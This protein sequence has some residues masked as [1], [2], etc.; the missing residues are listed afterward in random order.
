MREPPHFFAASERRAAATEMQSQRFESE[1]R[2][3]ARQRR[4]KALQQPA[5]QRRIGERAAMLLQDWQ[6]Q[7]PYQRDIEQDTLALARSHV[8]S[9]PTPCTAPAHARADP[10]QM[11]EARKV[12]P[13][14]DKIDEAVILLDRLQRS[15]A[16]G[17]NAMPPASLSTRQS[18]ASAGRSHSAISQVSSH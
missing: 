1:L 12:D 8:P 9:T 2:F 16:R 15:K 3:V 18:L 10:P 11:L 7:L 13:K 4:A 17:P 14:Q 5:R 6:D